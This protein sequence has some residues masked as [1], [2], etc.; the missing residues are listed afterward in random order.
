MS[1]RT[2]ELYTSLET[3]PCRCLDYCFVIYHPRS[4]LGTSTSKYCF[5][6]FVTYN[7][8]FITTLVSCV[9]RYLNHWSSLT[10][11]LTVFTDE[12]LYTRNRYFYNHLWHWYFCIIMASQQTN[13]GRLRDE[14][15]LPVPEASLIWDFWKY[16]CHR[17][18][19]ECLVC[20]G[21]LCNIAL[22]WKS[23][24]IP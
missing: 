4:R 24:P 19:L 9:Y 7:V 12:G 11:S 16:L 8:Q 23:Q 10:V 5:W 17:I 14:P 15:G 20:H 6:Q 22:I 1:R 3:F 2:T 13:S 21:N 18:C